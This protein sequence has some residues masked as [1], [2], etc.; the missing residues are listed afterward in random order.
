M[1]STVCYDNIVE[2]ALFENP[3]GQQFWSLTWGQKVIMMH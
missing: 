2:S 1:A 3:N